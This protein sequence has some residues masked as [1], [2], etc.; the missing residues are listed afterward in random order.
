FRLVT[1]FR[2]L[3]LSERLCAVTRYAARGDGAG[4]SPVVS[5]RCRG[6]GA[7]RCPP[8]DDRG[9]PP[10][11]LGSRVGGHRGAGRGDRRDPARGVF[12]LSPVQESVL[13]G[14]GIFTTPRPVPGRLLPVVGGGLVLLVA[15]PVFLLADWRLA[16]WALGA[17][18]WGSMQGVNFLLARLKE[19]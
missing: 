14:A 4:R 16:G 13:M 9:R 18:L 5:A 1:K 6:R 3:P 10:D 11:R 17:L 12:R 8:R 2:I 19:R 7:H 15:L